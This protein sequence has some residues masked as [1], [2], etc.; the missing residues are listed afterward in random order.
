M[1][2]I[3]YSNRCIYQ[4][5]HADLKAGMAFHIEI[6]VFILF[7]QSSGRAIAITLATT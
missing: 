1:N 6:A 4:L 5:A 7:G 2:L 3:K